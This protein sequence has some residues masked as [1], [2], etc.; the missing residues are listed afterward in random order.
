MIAVRLRPGL[1]SLE[2]EPCLLR[3]A[4]QDVFLDQRLDPLHAFAVDR[5]PG[6]LPIFSPGETRS[7]RIFR[8]QALLGFRLRT[9]E[10]SC[11]S[12]GYR[13]AAEGAGA[14]EISADG[15]AIAWTEREAVESDLLVEFLVGPALSLALALRGVFGLHAS[16]VVLQ[17]GAVAFLGE[18]GAGKSTLAALLDAGGRRLADDFLPV[19][20]SGGCL[21]AFSRFPQLKLAPEAQP[22]LN[23]PEELPLRAVYDLSVPSAHA[24]AHPLSTREAVLALVRHTVGAR[25]FG[26]DL[27]AAHL[28]FC[29]QVAKSLPVASLSYPRD[30]GIGA[31]VEALIL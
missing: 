4:G 15:S 26:P 9:V 2:L 24:H 19:A 16:A 14:F 18:S 29:G 11:G 7:H 13:V 17:E 28:A 1:P 21:K 12:G 31:E 20:W 3:I 8:E 6:E 23:H 5:Q 10:A 27:L 22:G 30:P 25:L